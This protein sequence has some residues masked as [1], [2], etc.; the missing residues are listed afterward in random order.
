V[1]KE[2]EKKKKEAKVPNYEKSYKL[3]LE[4]KT[5]PEIAEILGFVN[6]TI[7]NHLARYVATGNLDAD[8]FVDK[9][10]ID[11]IMKYY[12]QN[13]EVTTSDVKTHFGEDVSYGEIRMVQKHMEFLGS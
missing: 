4:G 2:E 9:K 5:I 3:Y 7:E 12:K 13:P 8:E 10:V 11:K 6:S 1:I